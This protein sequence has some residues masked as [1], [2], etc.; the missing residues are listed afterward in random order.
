MSQGHRASNGWGQDLNPGLHVPR[1]ETIK[2]WAQ[3]S[4]ASAL[5]GLDSECIWGLG[6]DKRGQKEHESCHCSKSCHDFNYI[7]SGI[8]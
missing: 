5:L 7:I 2:S 1:L 6:A 4:K 8:W 3:G